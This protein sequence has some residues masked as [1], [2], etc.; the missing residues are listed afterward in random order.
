MR[1][2]TLLLVI[3]GGSAIAD[4]LRTSG[5]DARSLPLLAFAACYPVVSLLL[6]SILPRPTARPG[7]WRFILR[8]REARLVSSLSMRACVVLIT[9]VIADLLRG[10]MNFKSVA[11]SFHQVSLAESGVLCGTLIMLV[12]I[13]FGIAPRLR[14]SRGPAA[15]NGAEGAGYCS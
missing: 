7:I 1:A 2:W 12:A 10:P 5:A 11:A 13:F 3:T 14:L 4:E 8:A 6:V 15:A 9:A